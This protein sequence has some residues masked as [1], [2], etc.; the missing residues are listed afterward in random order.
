MLVDYDSTYLELVLSCVK[1]RGKN[2]QFGWTY[3]NVTNC[4]LFVCLLTAVLVDDIIWRF[5]VVYLT[6]C[7]CYDVKKGQHHKNFYFWRLC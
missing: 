7:N 2:S 6:W 3:K 1:E 5:G 4:V